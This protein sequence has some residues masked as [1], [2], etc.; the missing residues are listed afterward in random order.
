M[1][2]VGFVFACP[3]F[4][5]ACLTYVKLV[6]IVTHE[7]VDDIRSITIKLTCIR[8]NVLLSGAESKKTT[9]FYVA[10]SMVYTIFAMMKSWTDIGSGPWSDGK[11]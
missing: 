3:C 10:V 5:L 7:N 2:N 11:F 4:K 8:P 1:Q 9:I 6:T